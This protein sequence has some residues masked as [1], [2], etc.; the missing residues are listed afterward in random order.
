MVG[1]AELHIFQKGFNFSQDGPGNRLVY[2]LKGCN[3]KCP[4]CSNPEGMNK[5]N[6]VGF[7]IEVRVLLEEILRSSPMFF[8]GGGVTFT[9]GECSL[10]FNSL[11]E[12]LSLLKENNINTAIETNGTHKNLAELYPLID[13]LIMDIK[14][15]EK[16]TLKEITGADLDI[17]KQNIVFA[18]EQNKVLALRIPLING[19]NADE[20]TVEKFIE[21]FKAINYGNL[22]VELLKYHEYGKD[23]WEQNGLEYKF[24]DGF[25]TDEFRNNFENKLKQN[26]INVVRT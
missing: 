3:L 21:F 16:E 22:T 11:K 4:W 14:H 1:L 19:F 10:Q 23:K 2:H 6:A 12:I 24:K 17:I 13:F 8:E 20:K 9:G 26:G 15:I 18:K 25:V 5:N 7:S